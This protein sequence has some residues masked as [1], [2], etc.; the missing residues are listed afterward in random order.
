MTVVGSRA[1]IT[2]RREPE[3]FQP[4]AVHPFRK[5]APTGHPTSTV[6]S[7]VWMACCRRSAVAMS[8]SATGMLCSSCVHAAPRPRRLSVAAAKTEV[9]SATLS[10]KAGARDQTGGHKRLDSSCE[11]ACNRHTGA[12]E[13]LR[14]VQG[15]FSVMAFADSQEQCRCLPW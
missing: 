5:P 4:C 3:P 6:L 14:A 1:S 15:G 10:C 12:V 7:T 9:S 11:S 2:E 8:E 13:R